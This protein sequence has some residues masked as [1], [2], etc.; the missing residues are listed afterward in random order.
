MVDHRFAVLDIEKRILAP[1]GGE[2]RDCAGLTASEA[3]AACADADAIIVGARFQLNAAALTTLERCRVI[4]R[5]GIGYDNID[6]S[7]AAAD[8]I[9]VATVPDYCIDEVADHTMASLLALNRRLAKLDSLVRCGSWGIPLGFAVRRLSECT[10]GVIGFGRIGEAVARRARAF[11]L[12]VLA[13]DPVRPEQDVR[14]AGAEPAQI[15]ELLPLADYVSLHAPR[16]DDGPL[17]DARRLAMLRHG[18][19][20]INVAR[21]GLIDEQALI[22]G[23]EAGSIGGAALDVAEAEPIDVHDPLLSAPNLIVTPHAAWYSKEAVVELREKAAAEAARVLAG[24]RP[25][26]PVNKPR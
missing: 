20:V 21:G 17:L 19:C 1:V 2:V 5:Y 11:G 6:V 24:E 12:R 13:H 23:L 7:T 18:A 10:L 15:D 26:H 4:V 8:G 14:A 22:R 25:L 9:W 3:L 16:A